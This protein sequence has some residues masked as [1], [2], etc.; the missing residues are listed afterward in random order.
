MLEDDEYDKAPFPPAKYPGR[1][2]FTMAVAALM[3]C[4]LIWKLIAWLI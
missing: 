3:V 2:A 1:E 4:F